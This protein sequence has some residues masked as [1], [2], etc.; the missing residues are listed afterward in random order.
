MAR[1]YNYK[2]AKS[3]SLVQAYVEIED[4]ARSLEAM[5]IPMGELSIVTKIVESLPEEKYQSFKDAWDSVDHQAQTMS[6]LLAR[7]KK[8]ELSRPNAPAEEDQQIT[9]A[10]QSRSNYRQPEKSDGSSKTTKINA[11]KKKTKC[12]NCG[13]LG[14][15]KRECRSKKKDSNPNKEDS[16]DD[17]PRAFMGKQEEH[18]GTKE[19][20]TSDSGATQ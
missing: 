19:K 6:N 2:I 11:L 16:R 9:K 12:H 20:W 18:T 8:L 4:L 5:G 13:K 1:F 7:L 15:W 14:H 17:T 3:Q 10:F